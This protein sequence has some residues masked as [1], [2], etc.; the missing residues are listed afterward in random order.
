[1][2]KSDLIREQQEL[3]REARAIYVGRTE[4]DRSFAA[5]LCRLR[6]I[7]QISKR[8]DDIAFHTH[9]RSEFAPDEQ[10]WHKS[11]SRSI[12][13]AVSHQYMTYALAHAH[14]DKLHEHAQAEDVTNWHSVNEARNGLRAHEAHMQANL[15][16]LG[17]LAGH[18]E[19]A[20]LLQQDI[21][22]LDALQS[23]HDMH[24]R[25]WS[26]FHPTFEMLEA[27]QTRRYAHHA[28]LDRLAAELHP[29]PQTPRQ[30][31]PQ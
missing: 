14:A 16:L 5:Q 31:A 20:A 15:Q 28:E 6:A 19:V 17:P 13:L 23:A 9:Q 22:Q 8:F 29:I 30:P 2:S 24:W 25:A 12:H 3:E 7:L 1:M 21:A 10:A 18:P 26:H 4:G 27:D 11:F